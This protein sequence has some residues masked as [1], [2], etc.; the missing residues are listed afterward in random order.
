MPFM[1]YLD[2]KATSCTTAKLTCSTFQQGELYNSLVKDSSKVVREFPA[3]L[4][5]SRAGGGSTLLYSTFVFSQIFYFTA[6]CAF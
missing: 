2:L 6:I 5:L 3:K 1:V 4:S